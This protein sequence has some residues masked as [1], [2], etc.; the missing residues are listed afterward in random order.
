MTVNHYLLIFLLSGMFLS[1]P[2]FSQKKMENQIN[3]LETEAG[4]LYDSKLWNEA[5]DIYLLLD[6]LI[7]MIRNTS[8]GWG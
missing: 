7:L 1:N 3:R 4:Q 6:S 8:S 2:S 5:M